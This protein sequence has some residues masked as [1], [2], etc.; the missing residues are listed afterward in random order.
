MGANPINNF[1]YKT[2]FNFMKAF[3]QNFTSAASVIDCSSIKRASTVA[4]KRFPLERVVPMTI[5]I[6]RLFFVHV[7]TTL[8]DNLCGILCTI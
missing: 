3:Y 2:L 1:L 5:P 8:R 7:A 6:F 4:P